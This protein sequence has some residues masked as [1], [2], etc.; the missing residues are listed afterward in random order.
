[1]NHEN[2]YKTNPVST[3]FYT[4]TTGF[5][6]I[7]DF[8]NAKNKINYPVEIFNYFRLLPTPYSLLPTPYSLL[9]NA[10]EIFNYFC[11]LPTPYSLFFRLLMFEV[12]K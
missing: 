1:M 12:Q 5:D 2:C 3:L 6:I 4:D 7:P 8:S 11:L 10:V 9:P